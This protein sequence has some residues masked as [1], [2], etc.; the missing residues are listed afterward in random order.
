M[1]KFTN[2]EKEDLRQASQS[3]KLRDDF[4]H[5][6]SNR[7][8]FRLQNGEIDLD[9][10]FGFVA[11]VNELIDHAPKPFKAITGNNFRI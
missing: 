6:S 7:F 11:G 5:L 3:E 10:I 1:D 8:E 2:Q 9:R 4:R